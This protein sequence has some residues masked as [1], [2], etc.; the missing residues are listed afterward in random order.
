M[1]FQQRLKS[2]EEFPSPRMIERRLRLK[3]KTLAIRNRP[4][5]KQSL[6]RNPSLLR[7]R[8]IHLMR[9]SK[10]R[11]LHK[12]VTGRRMSRVRVAKN[13]TKTKISKKCSKTLTGLNMEVIPKRC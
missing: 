2:L 11:R 5:P 4:T 3:R 8:R 7:K 9:M 6:N 10:I 13:S 12:I 1:R